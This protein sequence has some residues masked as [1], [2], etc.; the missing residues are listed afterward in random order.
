[1]SYKEEALREVF[2]DEKFCAVFV[3]DAASLSTLALSHFLRLTY[4]G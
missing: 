3:H 1:M 4:L 2:A